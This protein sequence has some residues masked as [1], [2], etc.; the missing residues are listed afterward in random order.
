MGEDRKLV[1]VISGDGGFKNVAEA[2]A[3]SN[4]T[5]VGLGFGNGNIAHAILNGV[6]GI[7]RPPQLSEPALAI[8]KEIHFLDVEI[9]GEPHHA[10]IGA[11]FGLTG[12]FVHLLNHPDHREQQGYA[13]SSWRYMTEL[14]MARQML[15][16]VIAGK[17]K[18][19]L[20]DD[21]ILS[22]DV[23]NGPLLAKYM[24]YPQVDLTSPQA[25]QLRLSRPE[26]LPTWVRHVQTGEWPGTPLSGNE[27]AELMISGRGT[28]AYVDGESYE[29]ELGSL[30]RVGIS[31]LT[32][33]AL[34]N[35]DA[36]VQVPRVAAMARL[37]GLVATHYMKKLRRK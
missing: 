33:P 36:H 37:S 23:M 9:N 14:A 30:F 18:V 3:Y 16:E 13:L 29:L 31:D 2:V 27:V 10:L 24:T 1:A 20:S 8:E 35:R 7:K 21:Q 34:A 6:R 12:R 19:K 15:R 4:S 22:Y 32:V 17:H 5:M 25:L 26:F 28:K 11:G